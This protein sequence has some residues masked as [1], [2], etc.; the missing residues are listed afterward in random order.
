[1]N[2]RSTEETPARLERL[3]LEQ[4]LPARVLFDPENFP[5]LLRAA[6]EAIR[7]PVLLSF[8][9][10]EALYPPP[11]TSAALPFDVE[12]AAIA[13]AVTEGLLR[14]RWFPFRR[15]CLRRALILANLLR[16]S[17]LETEIGFGVSPER[18]DLQG[19]AW[20]VLGGEPFLERGEDLA[21]YTCVFTLPR[22]E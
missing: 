11:S 14:A 18:A 17:G 9:R 10:V 19:H 7:L 1:M 13:V 20:L 12:K 22:R 3:I 5:F 16:G 2:E 15:T 6:W 8:R 4:P 21:G